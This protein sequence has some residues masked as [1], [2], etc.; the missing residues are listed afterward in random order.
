MNVELETL[1]HAVTS[2]LTSGE[3]SRNQYIETYQKLDFID[4]K[5]SLQNN[6]DLY[7]YGYGN[8]CI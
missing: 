2:V 3:A 7:T 8:R 1:E 5:G 4:Y 6:L